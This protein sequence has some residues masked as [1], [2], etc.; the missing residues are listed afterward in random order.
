M[1][2]LIEYIKFSWHRR[3]GRRRDMHAPGESQRA[4]R[5]LPEKLLE[6]LAGVS[7]CQI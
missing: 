5:N 3:D 1:I 7:M 6:Q 2:N 4:S